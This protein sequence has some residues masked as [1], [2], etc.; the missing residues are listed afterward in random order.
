M[1]IRAYGKVPREAISGANAAPYQVTGKRRRPGR[2]SWRLVERTTPPRQP[3]GAEPRVI[4]GP[5]TIRAPQS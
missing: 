3:D 2:I 4:S 5:V 1:P